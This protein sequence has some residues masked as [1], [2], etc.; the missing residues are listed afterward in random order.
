MISPELAHPDPM[1]AHESAQKISASL[2]DLL[3]EIPM[4]DKTDASV[5]EIYTE[6]SQ[7]LSADQIRKLELIILHKNL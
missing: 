5:Q 4:P 7:N 2:K 3:A 1:E 6:I